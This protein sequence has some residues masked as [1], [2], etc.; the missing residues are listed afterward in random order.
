MRTNE[1]KIV[2]VFQERK[3]CEGIGDEEVKD[4]EM[5]NTVTLCHRNIK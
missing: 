3:V 4:Y 2:I 5:K 1:S